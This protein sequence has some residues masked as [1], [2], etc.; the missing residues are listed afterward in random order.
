MSALRKQ[1]RRGSRARKDQEDRLG[2]Y[3]YSRE[4][5]RILWHFVLLQDAKRDQP[6]RFTK[7]PLVPKSDYH[8]TAYDKASLTDFLS[9]AINKGS[10]LLLGIAVAKTTVSRKIQ[11]NS[12]ST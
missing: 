7:A 9:S 2:G 3:G 10:D 11:R 1:P 8:H 4:S 5:D 6:S 12:A